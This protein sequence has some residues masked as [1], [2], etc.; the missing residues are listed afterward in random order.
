MGGG[1]GGLTLVVLVQEAKEPRG[2]EGPQPQGVVVVVVGF[3]QS[4]RV[5]DAVQ[6]LLG[7]GLDAPAAIELVGEWR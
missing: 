4:L 1:A 2:G 3:M 5:V 6:R 7:E